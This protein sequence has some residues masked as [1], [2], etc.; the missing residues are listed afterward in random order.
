MNAPTGAA[1]AKLPETAR[2]AV[3][4]A[5]HRQHAPGCWRDLVTWERATVSHDDVLTRLGVANDTALRAVLGAPENDFEFQRLVQGVR[6]EIAVE[7][8]AA[9]LPLELWRRANQVSN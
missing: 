1:A 4:E 9:K 5:A 7:R 8:A 3:V 6:D 2:K